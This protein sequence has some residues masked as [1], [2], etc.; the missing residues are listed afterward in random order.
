MS[1][2]ED[3]KFIC[4]SVKTHHPLQKDDEKINFRIPEKL[5]HLG[6]TQHGTFF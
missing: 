1:F 6:F 2:L 5:E 3:A 4:N